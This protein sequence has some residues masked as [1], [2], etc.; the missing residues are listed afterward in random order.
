MRAS[1]ENWNR[2]YDPTIGRYL[3]PEP[4]LSFGAGVAVRKVIFGGGPRQ[5]AEAV[6]AYAGNNPIND[7]DP[8]G[9][10]RYSVS[11]PSNPSGKLEFSSS[12][13]G[14]AD[15]AL[16]K[17]F[18]DGVCGGGDSAQCGCYSELANKICRIAEREDSG[19]RGCSDKRSD[20]CEAPAEVP[21]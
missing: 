9:L 2:Y 10:G 15:C 12:G 21:G 6:Y 16:A 3:Q 13:K 17:T 19:G 8:D 20:K 7:W 11:C 1:F 5:M 4:L 18:R 14:C